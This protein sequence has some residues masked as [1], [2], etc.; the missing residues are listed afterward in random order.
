MY[1]EGKFVEKDLRKADAYQRIVALQTGSKDIVPMRDEHMQNLL[2][3]FIV[4]PGDDETA[5]FYAKL[6]A[7][8]HGSPEDTDFL[9]AAKSFMRT[10][11]DSEAQKDKLR[12][13]MRAIIENPDKDTHGRIS[14]LG[15]YTER[16]GYKEEALKLY[17]LAARLR[18]ED[19]P[20]F[21]GCCLLTGLGV[22]VDGGKALQI[23]R[24]GAVKK[25]SLCESFLS[26]YAKTVKSEDFTSLDIDTA[27]RITEYLKYG[28]NTD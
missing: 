6:A 9:V 1:K 17:E 4:S 7:N 27:L 13:I 23:F 20:F 3:Q 5:R 12:Y 10:K 26:E 14:Y 28:F 2:N 8:S 19:Y 25:D 16:L 15:A 18:E 11:G 24:A 21:L 22:D